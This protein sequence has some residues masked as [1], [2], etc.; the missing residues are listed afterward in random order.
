MFGVILPSMGGLLWTLQ[1]FGVALILFMV[2]VPYHL[3]TREETRYVPFGRGEPQPTPEPAQKPE[4]LE[5][6]N[7]YA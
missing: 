5:F 1:W 4:P 7:Y 6:P 3:S 2:L